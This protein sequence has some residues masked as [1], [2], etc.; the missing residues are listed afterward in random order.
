V[1]AAIK[2]RIATA[3]EVV[4]V[5]VRRVKEVE[6]QTVVKTLKSPGT[7]V[8]K[9]T[10]LSA[11]LAAATVKAEQLEQ[12][13]SEADAKR[14]AAVAAALADKDVEVQEIVESFESQAEEIQ[15]AMNEVGTDQDTS[16]QELQ[17]AHERLLAETLRRHKQELK[18]T[19]ISKAQFEAKL[20]AALAENEA[21]KA[22]HKKRITAIR[23]ARLAAVY[24]LFDLDESGLL[25]AEEFF[26]IGRSCS[27]SHHSPD[28]DWHLEALC[29]AYPHLL[30]ILTLAV[31]WQ[32]AASRWGLEPRTQRKGL[33]LPRL[34]RHRVH[35]Q[36]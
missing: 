5:E 22:E 36:S 6:I 11:E 32:G 35:R 16:T 20:E 31:F 24:D 12:A 2:Q 19:E 33:W 7:D 14:E 30:L 26:D 34:E 28:C 17:R 18:S 15:A 29:A 8:E 10:R 13:L 4:R 9:L 1:E 27:S 21:G 3:V 25:D 23:E